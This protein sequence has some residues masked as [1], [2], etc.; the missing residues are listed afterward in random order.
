[1]DLSKAFDLIPH[2]LLIAKLHAYG[3]CLDSCN[4]MLSYLSDRPQRV[5]IGS[6]TSQWQVMKMGVPQGSLT[7]PLLFNIFINDLFYFLEDHCTIYNYADDNSLSVHNANPLLVKSKLESAAN[8]AIEWF[9]DNG[10]KA[11][12]D[13]FQAIVFGRNG[14]GS[15][16]VFNLSENITVKPSNHVKL[17]GLVIDNHLR[18]TQHI[19]ELSVKCSKLTNAIAR[20][21][22]LLNK[23]SKLSVL[24]AFLLS[25]LNYC[26]VIYH[27]CNSCDARKLERIQ[28]RFLRYVTLD[29]ESSYSEL[30]EQC[31]KP[32]LYVSR[33]RST[34]ECMFKIMNNALPPVDASLFTLNNCS[35][36]LRNQNTLVRPRVDTVHFGQK[37]MLA[38]GPKL[39]NEIPEHM[40]NVINLDDF[41]SLVRQWNPACSCGS[42]FLCSIACL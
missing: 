22:R 23:D 2:D 35:Y 6:Q 36:N 7:G 10:M 33:L 39:W 15:N 13:K 8:L 31:G 19:S 18:F 26:S 28:K 3:F 16:L 21:S 1:M 24:E 17:L 4:F 29:F 5:R 25:N 34:L 11:N 30:L 14:K 27:H 42:C 40:R 12:P 41:K 32:S 20:L 9:N 38:H 37:S